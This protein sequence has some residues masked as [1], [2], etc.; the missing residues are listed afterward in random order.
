LWRKKGICP[1]TLSCS[2]VE[3]SLLITLF[4]SIGSK[5]II[6]WTLASLVDCEL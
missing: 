1:P 4:L 2:K 5:E 6:V 3:M